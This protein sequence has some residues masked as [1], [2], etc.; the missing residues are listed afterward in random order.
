MND[1]QA[2][3]ILLLKAMPPDITAALENRF[4]LRRLD[5]AD[6]PDTFLAEHGPSIRGLA[7]NAQAPVGKDLLARLPNLEVISSFGV[8]YDT[9]D[10]AEAAQRGIVICNTPDVLSDEVAD[11][12]VGL[13]LATLRRIPQADAYLR[14]GGWMKAS[15]PLTATMRGRRVGILGLGRIGRAIARR[16]EGFDVG[17]AYHGRSRQADVPYAY[18]PTLVGMARA[19]DVLMIVAP[20]GA[21]TDGLVDASVLEALGPDGIVVNVARGSIID[22]PALIAALQAGTIHAAGLDVFARE[23]CA[24]DA[25]IALGNTVLLPHVGSG[26]HYTRAAMGRLLVDN[27]VS[28][29]DG[30]GPITPV[31]ETPW[32]PGR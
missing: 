26:S 3:D 22:E 11:L 8:G 5:A 7:L 2:P 28:W 19:C 30:K 9:L 4:R 6:D 12:A 15:F 14:A 20:G 18:H 27:L 17:I 32:E 29:F 1:A 13:L 10:T 24:P 25:L 31:P 21:G 23:P 16:L